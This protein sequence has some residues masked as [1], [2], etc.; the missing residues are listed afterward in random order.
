MSGSIK[1]QK[2]GK[3]KSEFRWGTGPD[4]RHSRLLPYRDLLL[5]SRPAKTH[6]SAAEGVWVT[7]Y[8]LRHPFRGVHEQYLF[9]ERYWGL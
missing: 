1:A 9:T 5:K 3:V 4:A 6:R 7:M 8:S 2:R